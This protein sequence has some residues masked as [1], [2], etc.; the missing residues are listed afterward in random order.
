MGKYTSENTRTCI[1]FKTMVS[2]KPNIY[3]LKNLSY[4]NL[5]ETGLTV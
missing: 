1:G 4:V 5:Y 2:W 3:L